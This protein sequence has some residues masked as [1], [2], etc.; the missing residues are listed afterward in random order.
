MKMR[1]VHAGSKFYFGQDVL[2]GADL[3]TEG[4]DILLAGV[5]M[6]AVTGLI[7]Q[8]GH[9]IR[10]GIP[11][12]VSDGDLLPRQINVPG[13]E[14]HQLPDGNDI[15]PMDPAEQIAGQHPLP[16]L[17]R[18]QH[19]GGRPILQHQPGIILPGLDIDDLPQIHFYESAF[20]TNKEKGLHATPI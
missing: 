17:Q 3:M 16:L 5:D 8:D 12:L 2:A 14:S 10:Q 15:P 18:D 1:K 11:V 19:L 20:M 13:I 9:R 4:E 7:G 6:P